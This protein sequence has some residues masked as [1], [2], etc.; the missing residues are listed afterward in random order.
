MK[1]I[2]LLTVLFSTGLLFFVAAPQAVAG[3][4][5]TSVAGNLVANC[6][7][8][9]G[10]FTGW[11][12]SG[13]DVPSE[14]NVLY[15]VEGTDP[16]D[17]IAPNSGSY[18]AFFADLSTSPTTISQNIAT[19]AGSTY[20]ISFYIAQDTNPNSGGSTYTN[21]FQ[22]SFGSS[23]LVASTVVPLQ[24]YTAYSFSEVATGPA[25]TLSL[26][27]GN[28]L[29]EFLLDDVSVAAPEPAAWSFM[30]G[31]LVLAY[32]LCRKSGLFFR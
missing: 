12:L 10:D 25:S 8:E 28:D 3:T 7:F 2:N 23:T 15:G 31:G 20:T 5:C 29:G 21:L 13:A 1:H 16:V 26:T 32:L 14:L 18:Q 9:T 30:A 19:A 4:S 22:A 24:G 11:T 17:N 27:F 6:G